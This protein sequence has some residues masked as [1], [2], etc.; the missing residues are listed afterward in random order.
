MTREVGQQLRKY[1]QGDYAPVPASAV[2]DTILFAIQLPPTVTLNDI[3]IRPTG[4]L[5]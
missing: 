2:A 1:A 5:A 3:T 4:D